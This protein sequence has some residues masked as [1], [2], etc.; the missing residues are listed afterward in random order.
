MNIIMTDYIAYR[1]VAGFQKVH[2]TWNL[3]TPLFFEFEEKHLFLGTKCLSLDGVYIC[4]FI[5]F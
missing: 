4:L 2:Q 3:L 5:Y 1:Y